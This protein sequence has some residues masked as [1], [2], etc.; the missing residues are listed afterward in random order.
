MNHTDSYDGP[1][2]QYQPRVDMVMRVSNDFTYHSPTANQ[3][4]RYE[5][6]RNQA[7][8]LAYEFL[9]QCPESR[10]LSLALT[11]LEEAVFFANAAIAR[12]EKEI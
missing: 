1:P 10:E 8:L 5:L 3:T 2:A 12:N 9:R 4:Q 6:L 11:K 7:K